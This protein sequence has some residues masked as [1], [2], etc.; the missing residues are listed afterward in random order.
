LTIVV[1]F[2][3]GAG[4][5]KSTLSADI[6]SR[7]KKLN[8]ETELAL[9]FAKDLV[10]EENESLKNQIYVFGNQLQRI[11]RVNNKVDVIVTD[12]PL[13]LSI[14]FRPNHIPKTLDKLVLETFNSY[15]N[16]NYFIERS[17]QYNPNG[18]LEKTVEEAIIKDNQI[19]Q[20]L[21]N[22]NIQYESVL[23]N[24]ECINNIVNDIVKIL[25]GVD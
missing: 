2:F 9:E 15:N 5:G 1:N 14:I 10:W 16:V 13:L 7:L 23:S 6:F 18:R 17:H 19:K 4:G 25:K 22:N 20:L 3:A 12:S 11:E 8:V 21:V 24:E